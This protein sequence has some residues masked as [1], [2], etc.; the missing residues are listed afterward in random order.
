[1]IFKN[2]C[3]KCVNTT[4]WSLA[5]N[6]TN[7]VKFR[8][9]AFF[10]FF[11]NFESP[12][13]AVQRDT[14]FRV[15]SHW[16]AMKLKQPITLLCFKAV[17]SELAQSSSLPVWNPSKCMHVLEPVHSVTLCRQFSPEIQRHVPCL[18][19]TADDE[20][21]KC[22]NC[23]KVF[24]SRTFKDYFIRCFKQLLVNESKWVKMRNWKIIIKQQ[25]L[26]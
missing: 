10:F 12:A 25:K 15:V 23:V 5:T 18:K 7:L 2:C 9:F 21:K 24:W 17:I 14:G 19:I 26:R 22:R 11:Y 6:F 13:V 16:S 4:C 8:I 20:N 1:M 3:S